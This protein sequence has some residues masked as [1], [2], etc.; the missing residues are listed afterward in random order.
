MLTLTVTDSEDS[1]EIDSVNYEVYRPL[2]RVDG[3]DSFIP[4]FMTLSF[5]CLYHRP[6]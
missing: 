3:K 6:L 2:L 4:V 1:K 5:L